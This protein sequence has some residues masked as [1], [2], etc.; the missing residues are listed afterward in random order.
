MKKYFFNKFS[1]TRI[2]PNSITFSRRQ[3]GPKQKH[4]TILQKEVTKKE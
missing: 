4:Y 3:R 1:F 2:T